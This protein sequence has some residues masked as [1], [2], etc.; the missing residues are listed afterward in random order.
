MSHNLYEHIVESQPII[1]PRYSTLECLHFFSIRV[2]VATE[3][4]ATIEVR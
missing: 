2:G 1:L 4:I 3:S